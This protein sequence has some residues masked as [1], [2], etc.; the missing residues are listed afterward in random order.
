MNTVHGKIRSAPEP[1]HIRAT[2][3]GAGCTIEGMASTDQPDSYGDIILAE[4][5]NT[6]RYKKNPVVLFGHN[7][8]GMPIGHATTVEIRP[9]GLWIRASIPGSWDASKEASAAMK[10]GSLKCLSVGFS[11]RTPG[12]MVDGHYVFGT[13][14]LM[15]ISAVAI[16]ANMDC[17]FTV[18]PQG[19][20]LA[21]AV[22]S[23]SA[24]VAKLKRQIKVLDAWLKVGDLKYA[25]RVRELR[26][27]VRQLVER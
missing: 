13:C 4:K 22:Q 1:F 21:I 3:D 12:K 14:K 8:K 18:D 5:W 19:K 9:H 17:T 2:P 16:P 10:A 11:E 27:A 24:L 20:L 26:N 25:N 23:H 6:A 7:A 15:E